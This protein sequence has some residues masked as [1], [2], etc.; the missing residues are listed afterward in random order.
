MEEEERDR[1]IDGN[2]ATPI[3]AARIWDVEEIQP[4]IHT[5]LTFSIRLRLSV[6]FKNDK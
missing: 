2:D 6:A 3:H 5:A 4:V 1:V